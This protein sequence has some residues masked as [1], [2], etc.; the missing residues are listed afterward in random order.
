MIPQLC[1]LKREESSQ[2][3]KCLN[4]LQL[5]KTQR[6]PQ[7]TAGPIP[8]PKT[9]TVTAAPGPSR[10]PP[11]TTTI[12]GSNFKQDRYPHPLAS[13]LTGTTISNSDLPCT[14]TLLF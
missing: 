2:E 9:A 13:C 5:V 3:I 6:L 8:T 14:S 11:T 7:G 1:D 4:Q 12:T 10:C